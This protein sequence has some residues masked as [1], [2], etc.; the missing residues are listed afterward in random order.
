MSTTIEVSETADESDEKELW[1]GVGEAAR[2][3]DVSERTLRR[4]HSRGKLKAR[5]RKG[6]LQYDAGGIEPDENDVADQI[7]ASTELLRAVKERE[8]AL[9]GVMLDAIKSTTEH[10]LKEN[11]ELRSHVSGVHGDV[12]RTSK[13]IDEAHTTMIEREA[14][15]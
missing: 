8:H 7:A 9:F 12:R 1:L 4:W 3:L 2:Q 15:I 13:L 10:V 6:V 14:G 5:K 11:T